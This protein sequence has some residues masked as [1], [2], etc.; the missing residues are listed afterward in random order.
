MIPNETV[1]SIVLTIARDNAMKVPLSGTHVF[2]NSETYEVEL[3]NSEFGV[4]DVY[5]GTLEEI[6]PYAELVAADA[7]SKFVLTCVREILEDALE[8]EL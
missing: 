8:E 2:I 6:D 1:K 4:E 3:S 7:D 5:F